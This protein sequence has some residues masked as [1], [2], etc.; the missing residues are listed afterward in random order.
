M[1]NNKFLTIERA[2][3]ELGISKQTLYRYEKKGV[4]PKPQRNAINRWR[5]Y[6]HEDIVKLKEIM[7]GHS[8]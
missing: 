2:A 3:Q 7:R 5:Q 1:I 6:T 8:E 4:F